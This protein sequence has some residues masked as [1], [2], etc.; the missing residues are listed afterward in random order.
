[1]RNL[2]PENKITSIPSDIKRKIRLKTKINLFYRINLS[3]NKLEDLKRKIKQFNNF[4]E[5][6]SKIA[7]Y[8]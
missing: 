8:K 4:S 7:T 2:E 5:I 1:M 3:L 6:I